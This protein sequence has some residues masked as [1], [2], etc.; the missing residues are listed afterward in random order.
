MKEQ[1]LQS[2]WK[3]AYMSGSDTWTHLPYEK[4]A[5]SFL[6]SFP[7]ESLVLDIGSGRGTWLVSL[8]RQKFRVI[9]IDYI[10]EIVKKANEELKERDI[11]ER[12]RF[13]VGDALDIPFVDTSFDIATDI[14]LLQHLP[15]Q[16]HTQYSR[17]VTRVVKNNG[18]F[19]L[20][21]LSDETKEWK[22][23]YPKEQENKTINFFDI[24]YN[25]FSK[26]DIL[27][28]FPDFKIAKEDSLAIP[29]AGTPATYSLY[30]LQKVQS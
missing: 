15:R 3:A 8:A 29:C 9:G 1:N 7:E 5:L 24:P 18:F 13:L 28:L 19:L 27:K 14:G 21:T 12:A 10:E 11:S 6:S 20:I 17:E 26:E 23:K 2:F 4:K 30:L 16:D 25:F 22:G